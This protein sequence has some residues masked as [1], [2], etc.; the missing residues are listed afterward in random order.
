MAAGG[1]GG[2]GEGVAALRKEGLLKMYVCQVSRLG[3][4]IMLGWL[5]GKKEKKQSSD[6]SVFRCSHD[7]LLNSC[8]STRSPAVIGRC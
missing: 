5:Q 6:R 7:Q 4:C 1:G 2:K 8:T 3:K